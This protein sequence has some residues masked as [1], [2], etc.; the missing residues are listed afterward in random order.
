MSDKLSPAGPTKPADI[1][2]LSQQQREGGVLFRKMVEDGLASL[3]NRA[4]KSPPPKT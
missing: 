2:P 3:K 4:S 1:R